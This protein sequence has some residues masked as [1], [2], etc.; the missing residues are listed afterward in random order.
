MYN[1]KT[2]EHHVLRAFL[3]S[4]ANLSAISREAAV[5]CGLQERDPTTIFLSTF[6]S[7]QKRQTFSKTTVTLKKQINSECQNITFHP[8]IMEKV[9]DPIT[10]YPT[11]FQQEIFLK[12]NNIVLSDDEVGGGKGLKVDL[13]LGQEVFHQFHCS[14]PKYIPGGVMIRSDL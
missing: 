4:G 7:E 5:K 6:N 10:S 14:G 9:M 3:D 12:E 11:S 8:F 13:L 1:D 2:G